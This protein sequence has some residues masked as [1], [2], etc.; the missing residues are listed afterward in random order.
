MAI[1]SIRHKGLRQLFQDDDSKG[2][3]A[4]F[5]EKLQRMLAASLGPLT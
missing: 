4:E 5:A 1:V 3:P 2:V